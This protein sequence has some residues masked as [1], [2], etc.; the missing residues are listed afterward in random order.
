MYKIGYI[1][2]HDTYMWSSCDPQDAYA[3]QRA[4]MALNMSFRVFCK[5]RECLL[6]DPSTG[7]KYLGYWGST[8]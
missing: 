6:V 3:M 5:G 8:R 2:D 1:T 4:L 7:T